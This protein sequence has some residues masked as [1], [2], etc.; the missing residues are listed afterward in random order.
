MSGWEDMQDCNNY[1]QIL[2][3]SS[4]QPVYEHR[5]QSHMRK[6]IDIDC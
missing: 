4:K 3:Y 1:V 2:N 5:V 6:A